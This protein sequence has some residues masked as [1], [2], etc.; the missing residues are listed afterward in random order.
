MKELIDKAKE[1]LESGKAAVVFGYARG[2]GEQVATPIFITRP[3]DAE[4]LIFDPFCYNNLAVFLTREDHKR[5]GRPAVVA[6]DADMRA[7]IVLVQEGQVEP[8]GA[9][10]LSV[11]CDEMGE[12]G[13]ECRFNGVMTIAEAARWLSEKYPDRRVPSARM[14]QV[15]KIEA[16][17]DAERWAFW[18]EELGRC[19]RCY[20]CRQACPMCYCRQCIADKNQPQWV[21]TGIH[22]AG[23][24]AWNVV[25][26]FHLAGRCI[27]CGECE[28]ACP[29]GIPLMALNRELAKI[30]KE[31]FDYAPGFEPDVKPVMANFKHEDK[32][33]F[34]K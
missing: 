22:P 20:A 2:T 31:S 8:D 25:R 15:E 19:I 9:L 16:M 14:K 4:H 23:A 10:L 6:K 28:R 27:D 1:L 24:F 33:D 11:S 7:A 30:V 17:S 5:L 12:A 21:M 29:M 26:A 32:E 34:F 13:A 18:R 3:E